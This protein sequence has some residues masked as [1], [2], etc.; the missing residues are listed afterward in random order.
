MRGQLIFLVGTLTLSLVSA[1][2]LSEKLHQQ[3]GTEGYFYGPTS[4]ESTLVV[5]RGRQGRYLVCLSDDQK[6]PFIYEVTKK[7]F[8]EGARSVFVRCQQGMLVV[9]KS[10]SLSRQVTA[11]FSFWS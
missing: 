2:D 10:W 1:G 6:E 3:L 9:S 5:E 7:F 8:P 4:P 11:G